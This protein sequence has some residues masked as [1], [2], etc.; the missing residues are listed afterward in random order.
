MQTW[1]LLYKSIDQFAPTYQIELL[2]CNLL[3]TANMTCIKKKNDFGTYH[4][5]IF[6]VEIE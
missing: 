3:Y 5:Y 2:W 6:E 4:F 1:I